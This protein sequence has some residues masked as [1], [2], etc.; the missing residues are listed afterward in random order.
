MATSVTPPP[1]T[2]SKDAKA[3]RIGFLKNLSMRRKKVVSNDPS[4]EMGCDTSI[5]SSIPS[6]VERA[7]SVEEEDSFFLQLESG[8]LG[9]PLT[10]QS[11][12]APLKEQPKSGQFI[13]EDDFLWSNPGST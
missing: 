8:E 3:P 2:E 6:R 4:C 9:A 1:P 7:A 13:S 5:S 11:S 12:M 10:P